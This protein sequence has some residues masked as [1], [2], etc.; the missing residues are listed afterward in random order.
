[1][2]PRNSR[3]NPM[4]KRST[5]RDQMELSLKRLAAWTPPGS[6]HPSTPAPGEVTPVNEHGEGQF[7]GHNAPLDGHKSGVF[8]ASSR[9][10]EKSSFFIGQLQ[11]AQTG[12]PPANKVLSRPRSACL[13]GYMKLR[14]DLELRTDNQRTSKPQN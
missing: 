9:R 12:Q 8:G 13:I 14:A 5:G 6:L 1:M 7:T 3:S 10:W 11:S 4:L 2:A